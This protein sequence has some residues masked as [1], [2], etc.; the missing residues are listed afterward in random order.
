MAKKTLSRHIFN[1]GK[2]DNFLKDAN[3]RTGYEADACPAYTQYVCHVRQT[4]SRSLKI[5]FEV[6]N[7]SDA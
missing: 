3:G 6:M 1:K 2:A 7:V 5:D 4:L